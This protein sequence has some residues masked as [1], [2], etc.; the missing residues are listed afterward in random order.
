V[1]SALD[2]R[3]ISLVL[4]VGVVIVAVANAVHPVNPRPDDQLQWIPICRATPSWN[5]IHWGLG[6]GTLLLNTAVALVAHRLVGELAGA[7][8]AAARAAVYL[9]V[10]SIPVMMGLAATEVAVKDMLDR[11]AADPGAVAAV[12]PLVFLGSGLFGAFAI[13]LWTGTLLF[14]L[15]L[16]ASARFPRWLGWIGALLGAWIVLAVG[17]PR[18]AWG[19]TAWTDGPAFDIAAVLTLAWLLAVAW[20]E[21]RHAKA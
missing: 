17:L 11:A 12:R 19:P 13:T 4:V 9:A 18:A 10:A 14:G 6:I 5:L 15:A 21:W 7:A 1:Q 16:A 8:S 20:F 2:R 3:L